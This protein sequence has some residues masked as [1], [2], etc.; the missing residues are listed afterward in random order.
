MRRGGRLLAATIGRGAARGPR[1][2]MTSAL[3]TEG[4]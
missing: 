4:F 1:L 2:F 3:A